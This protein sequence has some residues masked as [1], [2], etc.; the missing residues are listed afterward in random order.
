MPRTGKRGKYKL[1]AL[2]PKQKNMFNFLVEYIHKNGFPPSIRETGDAVGINSTSVVNY[3]LNKLEEHRLISRWREVSRAIKI[4]YPR[5]RELG[6]QVDDTDDNKVMAVPVLGHIVA[7]NPVDI[8]QVHTWQSAEEW[9]DISPELVDDPRYVFALRVIG[10]SMIDANVADNDLVLIRPTTTPRN[11]DM[12]SAWIEGDSEMTLK[13]Y[14]LEG[15]NVRLQPSSPD[16]R[17]QPIVRP[18][19]KVKIQ[20]KVLAVIRRTF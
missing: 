11:G 19:D 10:D 12:V 3:N 8:G 2:S 9:I 1:R 6:F 7:S 15:D 13:R 14:Y 16:P 18:I 17:Y 5:A 20:G 4:N